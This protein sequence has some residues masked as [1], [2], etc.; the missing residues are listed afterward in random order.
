MSKYAAGAARYRLIRGPTPVRKSG[1]R[2]HCCVQS[3]MAQSRMDTIPNGRNPERTGSR[4]TRS[5]IDT[6]PNEHILE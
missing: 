4:M 6:I 5:Q 3:Q 1:D 2:D